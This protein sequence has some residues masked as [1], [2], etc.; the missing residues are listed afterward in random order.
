MDLQALTEQDRQRG[1]AKR[2]IEALWSGHDRDRLVGTR[3]HPNRMAIVFQLLVCSLAI[4]QQIAAA[5]ARPAVIRE[6]F[7]FPTTHI[8]TRGIFTADG[9]TDSPPATAAHGH[10]TVLPALDPPCSSLRRLTPAGKS[11]LVDARGPVWHAPCPAPSEQGSWVL[12]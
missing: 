12:R 6:S 11:T 7:A 4:G 3:L 2:A 9:Q 10:R 5:G 8:D 1:R